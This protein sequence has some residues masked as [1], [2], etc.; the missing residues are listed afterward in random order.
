MGG[1]TL[2]GD[3]TTDG[4]SEFTE[5]IPHGHKRPRGRPRTRW[6]IDLIQYVG[7]TWS[8]IAKDK[9]VCK[10]CREGFLLREREDTLTDDD[11]D[12]DDKDEND[13]E[14]DHDDR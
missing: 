12:D 14:D 11:D 8:H 4:Q 6:C 3:V 9:E 7:P 10:A 1:I 13:D 2:R 5:W